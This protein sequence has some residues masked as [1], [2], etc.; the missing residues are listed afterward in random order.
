[1]NEILFTAAAAPFVAAVTY[2][3]TALV[4]TVFHRWFG[5]QPRV[6]TIHHNH[7]TGHHATYSGG[8]LLSE[9]W[10]ASERHVLWYYAFPLLPVAAGASLLLPFALFLVHIASVAASV[11]VHLW[12]HRQYHL[13]ETWLNRYAWFRC[14]QRLHFVH[15]RHATSNYAIIEYRLDRLMGTFSDRPVTPDA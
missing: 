10:E 12:L 4:Q 1:M 3:L 8:H 11:W 13:R 7:V 5:H 9:S 6:E 14:K 2:Y 15:H